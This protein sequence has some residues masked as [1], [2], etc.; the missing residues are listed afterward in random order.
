MKMKILNLTYHSGCMNEVE[1]ICKKLNLDS[2]AINAID[3]VKT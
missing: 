2:T 3:F 1:Y